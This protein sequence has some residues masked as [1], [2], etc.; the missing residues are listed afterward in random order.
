MTGGSTF[1]NKG[2]NGRWKD[3][4][5]EADLAKYAAKVEEKLS[6]ACARWLETGEL[7]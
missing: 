6:P 5:T 2:T 1:I 7:P 3:M 4:L